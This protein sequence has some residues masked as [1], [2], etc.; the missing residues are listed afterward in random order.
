MKTIDKN[1]TSETFLGITI[2]NI[3]SFSLNI[4]RNN[5]KHKTFSEVSTVHQYTLIVN[6]RF[7]LRLDLFITMLCNSITQRLLSIKI[8]LP[9]LFSESLSPIFYHSARISAEIIKNT[10]HF[11]GVSGT[12]ARHYGYSQ[13]EGSADWRDIFLEAVFSIYDSGRSLENS[14]TTLVYPSRNP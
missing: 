12:R 7:V 6:F 10:R 2:T 11:T 8:L 3:L 5:K 14:V 9:K 1:I 4:G 13:N